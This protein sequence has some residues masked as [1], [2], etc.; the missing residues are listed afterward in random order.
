M[1]EEIVRWAS[2][3]L[4]FRRTATQDTTVGEQDI[5]AGD[6]IVM[7]YGSGN[8]DEA[9]FV[10]PWRFDVARRPNDHVGFGGGGPHFCLGANLARVQI[11]SVFAELARS[12]DRFEVDDVA[13]LPGAFVNGIRR[14]NC[15]FSLDSSVDG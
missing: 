7:F 2:P 14:V 11:R 10:D 1:V 8:R 12:V 13:Y 6:H 4:T 15:N 9:V 3:V 5:E